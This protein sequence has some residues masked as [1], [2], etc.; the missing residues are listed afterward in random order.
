MTTIYINGKFLCQK[1]S[2]VQRYAREVTL[3]IDRL[4]SSWGDLKFVLIA[5][6]QDYDES[7]KTENIEII[8]IDAAPSYKYEQLTLPKYLKKKEGYL[9]NL[10]NVAPIK[11]KKRNIFTLHDTAFYSHPE[12]FTKKFVFV[13]KFIT[14]RTLP[15]SKLVFTVSKFSKREILDHFKVNE[16]DIY[17][18]PNAV[19]EDFGTH[20][21]PIKEEFKEIV[22]NEFFFSV[23]SWSKN[24]NMAYVC[25]L[26]QK[27]KDK[28]FV[29]S[30]DKA[31]AFAELEID[32][33]DN[34]HFLGR[35][36]D[37]ELAFFY[38]KAKGFIFPSIYEGFGIP[39]IEAIHCGCRCIIASNIPTLKEILEDTANYIDPHDYDNLPDLDNLKVM[40]K[41]QAQKI[42]KKYSWD[43]S[44]KKVIETLQKAIS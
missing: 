17:V 23:G 43:S 40:S 16:D 33:P 5:P 32:I 27:N 21:K 8:K 9:L 39:P 37:D 7:F 24:K 25:Q 13:Y 29:I 22:K 31:K 18:V 12:F 36:D 26:A 11:L 38:S 19:A 35:L 10:A 44:A 30:G 14:Q 3:G 20:H 6:T 28:M 42:K 4:V 34:V 2:G 41:E 15:K 1:T